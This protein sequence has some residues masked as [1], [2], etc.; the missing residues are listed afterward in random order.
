[1]STTHVQNLESKNSMFCKG[2]IEKT[3]QIHSRLKKVN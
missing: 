3:T 1:M 2:K